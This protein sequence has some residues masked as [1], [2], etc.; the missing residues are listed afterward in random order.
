LVLVRCRIRLRQGARLGRVILARL[1]PRSVEREL[2]SSF[3]RRVDDGFLHR[4]GIF[5]LDRLARERAATLLSRHLTSLQRR[6]LRERGYFIVGTR[7]GRRFRIWARRQLPVELMDSDNC[8]RRERQLY[9]I[10]VDDAD[11][12]SVMPLADYLFELKLCLEAD[13]ELFVLTSNPMFDQ[14][15]IEKNRLLL[16]KAGGVERRR[17]APEIF[18]DE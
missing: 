12:A 4:Y 5:S 2:F 18:H 14:G 13:E 6:C 17:I 9:C 8:C 3:T 15:R 16:R 7:S 10:T 11:A 1:L